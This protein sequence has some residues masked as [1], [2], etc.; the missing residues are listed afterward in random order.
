MFDV[1]TIGAAT[2]DIFLL[3][4]DLSEN[5]RFLSIKKS[6][7]NEISRSLISSGGGAINSAITFSRLGFKSAVVAQVGID[8]LSAYVIDD[9]KKEK[10]SSSLLKSTLKHPTDFSIILV[11]QDGSR[12]IFT[13]RG[14]ARLE[15]R[16]IPWSKIK[17]CRWL[18]LTSLEG[19]LSL[20][21]KLIGFAKEN[22]LGI[23]FNPGHRELIQRRQL[24]PLLRYLDFLLLNR[25][26]AEVLSNISH[27]EAAFYPTIQH[28][29]PLVAVTNGRQGAK[30]LTADNSYF[31]PIINQ[32]PIDETGAGDAFGSAFVAATL[33]GQSIT[34]A[35][36]WASQNSAS[37]VG[38]FGA[39]E[40]ILTLKKI[41][42]ASKT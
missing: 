29:A 5:R 10:I 19:N 20:L 31:M 14:P 4:D 11:G 3:S 22:N 12:S 39:K 21:E 42:Y 41:K 16:D 36:N 37:V 35:L 1:I 40:G 23:S 24:L 28:Y 13:Q 32:H 2:T 30:I 9:L 34:Q 6:S 17:K 7:K 38:Y 25:H 33:H 27:K 18:Y 15:D 8:P 26:E